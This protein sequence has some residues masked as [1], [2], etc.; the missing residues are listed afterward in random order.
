M[1]STCP[2]CG[3]KDV[4]SFVQHHRRHP[5]CRRSTDSLS[6]TRAQ[7]SQVVALPQLPDNKPSDEVFDD[8]ATTEFFDNQLHLVMSGM[9]SLFK[10]Y[11]R[12]EVMDSCLAIANGVIQCLEQRV[13]L[14]DGDA[15]AITTAFA[16]TQRALSKA[17]SEEKRAAYNRRVL[18][19]PYLEP[20]TFKSIS[21]QQSK[22]DAVRLSVVKTLA[23]VLQQNRKVGVSRYAASPM[24]T[25][26]PLARAGPI[27]MIAEA[28]A[29]EGTPHRVL[30]VA[31]ERRAAQ[32]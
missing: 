21:V 5:E 1:H 22:R 16:A 17:N 32:R 13:K 19:V 7:V 12:P 30:G 18:K 3:C 8:V 9:N 4:V 24:S 10:R 2:T 31:E 29:S 20:I 26:V 6:E 23:R 15:A 27:Q 28:T 11:A 14:L 25:P